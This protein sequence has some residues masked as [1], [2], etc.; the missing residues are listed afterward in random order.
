MK[1][2]EKISLYIRMK[3]YIHSSMK[4]RKT[5][6]VRKMKER[7]FHLSFDGGWTDLDDSVS[8]LHLAGVGTKEPVR[9]SH[10]QNK[11]AK[12]R[13]GEGWGWV[14]SVVFLVMAVV[15]ICAQDY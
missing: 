5:V 7:E 3:Q 9:N 6:N 13:G 11:T 8:L 4:L 15:C 10:L 12:T 2:Q 1:K 14:T